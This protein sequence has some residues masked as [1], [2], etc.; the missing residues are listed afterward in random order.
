MKIE[1]LV[2][3]C[4]G[5]LLIAF[6]AGGSYMH[7]NDGERISELESQLGVLKKQEEKSDV[8][9][10]VS[11]QMEKI[12]NGQQILAEERSREAIRQA[13]I[14]QAATLRSEADREKALRAQAAAE[15]S[16]E[17]AK[18]SYLMA[19][20]Q[21]QEADNQRRQAEHAKLVADTLSYTSLGRTL[22]TQSY[23]ILLSG[24]KEIGNMLA[25]AAYLYTSNYGGDLYNPSVFQALIQAAGGR[26]SWAVHDSRISSIE[27]SP[28]DG[29]LLSVGTY[30]EFFVNR[31]KG[32]QI[33]TSRL[34]DDKNYCFRDIYVTE[35]GKSYAVSHTGH[36][37]I[38]NGSQTQIVYLENVNRP[39]SLEDMHDGRQ[40]LIIGENSMALLDV[41]T[42]KV[43]STRR[44]N[45]SVVCTGKRGN[46]PLLFDNHGRMHLVNGLDQVT[47]E[48]IPV[49]GQVSAYEYS[50]KDRLTA[51]GMTDG[52]IWM[53]DGSGKA[54]KLVG[55]LSKVTK[56][57]LHGKRL[58]SS[59]NDGKL[60]FWMTGDMQIKPI[61]L[62]QSSS[63]LTDF[64]FSRNEDYIL[65]GEKDG[66]ISEYLISLPKIAQRIRQNVKRNFTQ[67]EWEYYVGKG[68]PYMAVKSE[69]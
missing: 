60:L 21:R 61:T 5:G 41:A 37:V 12:A 52:T 62:F 11:Q 27:I 56:M 13:E 3:G 22:G 63:W 57:R 58:Y 29:S 14:A 17:E 24:D 67:E 25:Y 23:T 4:L 49:P 10:R 28:K 32:D 47:S 53:I 36:L 35:N 43:I 18:N 66:T 26:R 59:S 38:A 48:K 2:I 30:G 39:F 42:D 15:V 8:D 20:Q 19:E 31:I 51:Y 34:M 1:K 65:M 64:T 9:R 55:H 6:A 69:R 40:L 54:H 16:A 50:Q 44:L 45:F 7:R 68:I 46:K 33:S